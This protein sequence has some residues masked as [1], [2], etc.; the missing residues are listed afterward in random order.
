MDFASGKA[1]APLAELRFTPSKELLDPE[2]AVPKLAQSE[3]AF[4]LVGGS[5]VDTNDVHGS[6]MHGG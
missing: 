1:I 2:R 4:P 3:T 6:V 5:P